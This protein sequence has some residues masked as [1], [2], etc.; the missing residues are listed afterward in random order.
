MEETI[1]STRDIAIKIKNE[2]K[3]EK[4]RISKP[5]KDSDLATFLPTAYTGSDP[6][7]KPSP[8]GILA[9]S[10]LPILSSYPQVVTEVGPS[11]CT[12]TGSHTVIDNSSY[13]KAITNTQSAHGDGNENG[14]GDTQ[15]HTNTHTDA[16]KDKDT[17]TACDNGNVNGL[18]PGISATVSSSLSTVIASHSRTL[19]RTVSPIQFS[20][21]LFQPIPEALPFIADDSRPLT[22]NEPLAARSTYVTPSKKNLSTEDP[23]IGSSDITPYLERNQSANVSFGAIYPEDNLPVVFNPLL[24]LPYSLSD[25][26]MAAKTAHKANTHDVLVHTDTKNSVKSLTSETANLSL[27][28][29]HK[30]E[31]A[32]TNIIIKEGS[33]H[34]NSGKIEEINLSNSTKN[35][36]KSLSG[37]FVSDVGNEVTKTTKLV[38]TDTAPKMYSSPPSQIN[39]ARQRIEKNDRPMSRSSV[40]SISGSAVVSV[41]ESIPG[42]AVVL[43]TEFMQGSVNGWDSRE[44]D[45]PL[46][47]IRPFKVSSPSISPPPSYSSQK[48]LSASDPPLLSASAPNHLFSSSAALSPPPTYSSHEIHAPATAPASFPPLE[49]M[50]PTPRSSPPAPTLEAYTPPR[51]SQFIFQPTPG[52]PPQPSITPRLHSVQNSSESTEDGIQN[53]RDTFQCGN[54]LSIS[55]MKKDLMKNFDMSESFDPAA[56][57]PRAQDLSNERIVGSGT[58]PDDGFVTLRASLVAEVYVCYFF[59]CVCVC[60]CVFACVC[61]CTRMVQ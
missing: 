24:F 25:P 37:S 33:L 45:D 4:R 17:Y 56:V 7:P 40:G 39:S 30:K 13:N 34:N 44:I 46:L 21:L 28:R 2:I 42:S 22:Y 51:G 16:D 14:D 19:S 58:K 31:H 60:V 49:L 1:I 57:L 29:Y 27:D 10:P 12:N 53:I 9:S 23:I 55:V 41:Q 32:P 8:N 54:S 36:P 5:V 11:I 15:T 59:L 52:T 6:V 26:S 48:P 61:V 3:E 43:V 18:N 47:T 50:R 38:V 35:V 20:S